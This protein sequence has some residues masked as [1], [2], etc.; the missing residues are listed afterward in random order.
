MKTIYIS[1][2]IIALQLLIGCTEEQTFSFTAHELQKVNFTAVNVTLNHTTQAADTAF[3]SLRNSDWYYGEHRP[4]PII[5]GLTVYNHLDGAPYTYS[6]ENLYSNAVL[7]AGNNTLS[8]RF[9][10]SCPEEKEAVFT[11]P[12]GTECVL[13]ASNPTVEWTLNYDTYWAAKKRAESMDLGYYDHLHVTARSSYTKDGDFYDNEGYILIEVNE[14]IE[15]D[16]DGK[17]YRNSWING[18]NHYSS[19]QPF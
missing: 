8:F 13:N 17:W 11:M 4:Q 3:S 10:P 5:F 16:P 19:N 18:Y 12:N 2:I 14:D 1:T 6:W 7:A 15:Y 9:I